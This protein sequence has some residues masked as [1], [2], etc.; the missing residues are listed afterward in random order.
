M[1]GTHR[2]PRRNLARFSLASKAGFLGAI[3]LI[4]PVIL[5][6]QFLDADQQKRTLLTSGV[7]MQGRTI[8]EALTPLLSDA[9]T[10]NL[11]AIG[12][13]LARF[14]NPLTGIRLLY[15]PTGGDH[16]GSGFYYVASSAPLPNAALDAERT[17]LERQ[18][19]LDRLD[20]SCEGDVQ[21]ELRYTAPDGH[22][23]IVTS[24]TPVH[25]P[26]GCWVVVTSLSAAAVPG[27]VLGR[28]YYDSPE[29]RIAGII[30]VATFALT[31]ALIWS[32]WRGLQR[33]GERARLIRAHQSGGPTFLATNAV[34]ELA[35]VAEEFDRMVETLQQAARDLRR[36]AED[37][38]HAFKTPVA[39]IRQSLEPITKAVPAGNARA[40]RAVGLI[41][42]SL[43]KL[44]GLVASARRLDEATADLLDM[45]RVEIDLSG[46]IDRVLASHVELFRQRKLT[47]D[48]I[49]APGVAI[50]GNEDMVETVIE[51]VLEN[52]VSFSA[53][54]DTLMVRLAPSGDWAELVIADQGPGVR[55]ADLP[56][57]FDRYYS[58]RPVPED[59]DDQA[60]HFG[61]GLWIVRRNIEALGGQVSAE[62]HEPHGLAMRI[63]LP[64]KRGRDGV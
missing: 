59:G 44:D 15:R 30:Y 22:D 34:P 54:G 21:V 5:Y 37:N 36:A 31:F 3:F 58:S 46:L 33:F 51:N 39:I 16:L 23:E 40:E 62:K 47:L 55:E 48:A 28:P 4:V 38:A 11:P 63:H 45:P 25:A 24:V 12:R 9:G 57:I 60:V 18:G 19:V 14:D 32:I 20:E 64:L 29:V 49:V 56:R 10:P 1:S 2:Q 52:A 43:D 61:V 13:A 27:E 7:H 6:F 50:R 17:S 53:A 8:A 42:R 35:G 41:E 26:N